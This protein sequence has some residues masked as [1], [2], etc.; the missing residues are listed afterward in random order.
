MCTP[1]GLKRFFIFEDYFGQRGEVLSFWTFDQRPA[2]SK[3]KLNLAS[4]NREVKKWVSEA[5]TS[6]S[7]SWRHPRLKQRVTHRFCCRECGERFVALRDDARFCS[8]ACKQANYRRRGAVIAPKN[9][10]NCRTNRFKMSSAAA[11]MRLMR[12]RKR[13]GVVPLTV[14][15]F[16]VCR[17]KNKDRRQ[18]ARRKP[19]RLAHYRETPTASRLIRSSTRPRTLPTMSTSASGADGRS[20]G[21]NASPM[22]AFWP[23]A[24][25]TGQKSKREARS[26]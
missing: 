1:P 6:P 15:A 4:S 20:S 24:V 3:H 23:S 9:G 12:E 10:K 8:S 26:G 22:T 18:Q 7:L 13:A 17:E 21:S 16:F 5:H 25:F 2:G 14:A 11:R 19:D